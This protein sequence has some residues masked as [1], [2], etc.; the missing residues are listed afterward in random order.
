[1]GVKV[2]T[3]ANATPIVMN[4]QELHASIFDRDPYGSGPCIETVFYE[5]LESRSWSEG[6]IGRGSMRT[7]ER[8]L[9]YV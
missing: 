2:K 9:T 6:W 7:M 4:L 5:F 1:M 3:Y 8:L